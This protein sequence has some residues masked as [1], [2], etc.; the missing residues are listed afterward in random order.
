[1]PHVSFC[2]CLVCTTSVS[3]GYGVDG[4]RDRRLPKFPEQTG[5]VT[6]TVRA[7][8][9][10]WDSLARRFLG[11]GGVPTVPAA[12]PGTRPRRCG[13]LSER[14]A[15]P[16]PCPVVGIT[17]THAL[18]YSAGRPLT[19]SRY[20]GRGRVFMAVYSVSDDIDGSTYPSPGPSETRWLRGEPLHTLK[21]HRPRLSRVPGHFVC[22]VAERAQP[23]HIMIRKRD[24]LTC[25]DTGNSG[26]IVSL[27]CQL[28][29]HC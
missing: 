20:P 18:I 14:L 10:R 28:F 9:R 17:P 24:F 3:R 29:S 19:A 6:K 21:V 2:I 11:A 16:S 8:L 15:S 27:S 7:L 12:A 4:C 22:A 26:D 25:A 13:S 5:V 23:L 1:M